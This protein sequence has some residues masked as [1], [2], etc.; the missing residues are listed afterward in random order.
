MRIDATS[1]RGSR[2]AAR[3]RHAGQAAPLAVALALWLPEGS[4][5]FRQ[6]RPT[7]RYLGENVELPHNMLLNL[8]G[9]PCLVE[10][11]GVAAAP[12]S[13]EPPG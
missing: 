12:L 2:A 9:R 1:W 7:L 6:R 5:A 4:P 3:A 8:C 11:E 13:S 10:N